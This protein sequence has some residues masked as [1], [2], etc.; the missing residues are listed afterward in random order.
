[1]EFEQANDLLQPGYLPVESGYMELSD[2]KRLVAAYARLSRQDG[3]LVVQLA[4]G[5]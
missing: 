1:M 4:R 2:G 3:E 5:N